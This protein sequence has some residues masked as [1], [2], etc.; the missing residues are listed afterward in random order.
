MIAEEI[1]TE[2]IKTRIGSLEFTHGDRSGPPPL[3]PRRLEDGHG[4]EE[5]GAAGD[6]DDQGRRRE[7]VHG[8]CPI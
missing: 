8:S 7:R 2:K 5:G 1:I 4:R 6:F 3:P